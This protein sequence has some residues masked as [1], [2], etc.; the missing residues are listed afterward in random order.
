MMTGTI[1]TIITSDH[2]HFL[3][4]WPPWTLQWRLPAWRQHSPLLVNLILRS[5]L[6][7]RTSF[8]NTRNHLLK[9][10]YI[11]RIE[12][13]LSIQRELIAL[14]LSFS[15]AGPFTVFAPRELMALS[16]SFSFPGPFTVFAPTNLAFEKIPSADLQVIPLCDILWMWFQSLI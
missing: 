14:W 2:D 10:S 3:C 16:L 7:M 11:G 1:I 5:I 9:S 4:S 13:W 12:K 8:F 15:F 6:L